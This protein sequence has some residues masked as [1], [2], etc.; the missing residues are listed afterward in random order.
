VK[1]EHF[2]A[3][4][5]SLYYLSSGSRGILSSF[6]GSNKYSSCMSVLFECFVLVI[7][8]GES[9][10]FV[11]FLLAGFKG[12]MAAGC[13]NGLYWS[14]W[15]AILTTSTARGGTCFVTGTALGAGGFFWIEFDFFWILMTVRGFYTPKGSYS[16]Q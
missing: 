12:L 13:L 15:L 9:R 2:N 10:R 8:V 11:G 16:S 3:T 5:I 4:N 6:D 7:S 1:D 14:G